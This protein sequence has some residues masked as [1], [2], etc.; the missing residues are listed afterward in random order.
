MLIAARER[1]LA[2]LPGEILDGHVPEA[3]LP[4]GFRSAA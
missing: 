1:I 2:G 4:K 3:G